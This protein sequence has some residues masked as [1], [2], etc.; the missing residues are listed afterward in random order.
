[1]ISHV[2]IGVNNFDLAVEFY[3]GIM[4][5]MGFRLQFNET[6]KSWAGWVG[7][8]S[9]R[10]LFLIGRPHNN[11]DATAGNGQMVAL[12][13]SSREVVE[14]VHARALSS[15]G[16]CEG[17]P[18]P[19]LHYH[20]EYYGAYFRDLDGNKICVCYHGRLSLPDYET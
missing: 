20:P 7:P 5:E 12:L 4:D 11:Q 6:E 14:R 9:P 1:M 13:A 17:K 10:P 3:S 8:T 16:I 19:R 18:G 15:G 2:F